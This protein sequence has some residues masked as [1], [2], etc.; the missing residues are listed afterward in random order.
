L[1]DLRVC[2]GGGLSPQPECRRFE[3]PAEPG[4]AQPKRRIRLAGAAIRKAV[5][6][7]RAVGYVVTFP[8]GPNPD[9]HPIALTGGTT[10]PPRVVQSAFELDMVVEGRQDRDWPCRTI[11]MT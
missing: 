2:A 3:R 6:Q 10:R 5:E 9:A 4:R 1:P 7:L 8:E 11:W